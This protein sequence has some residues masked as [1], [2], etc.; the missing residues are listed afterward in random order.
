MNKALR[1]ALTC[2]PVI[3]GG[4]AVRPSATTRI[5]YSLLRALCK[6]LLAATGGVKVEGM[7]NL[8]VQGALILV[9]NHQSLL[10]PLVLM[11]C[12]P[13]RITFL[14][15][16]YL[17]Q[18]PVVGQVI[19]SAGSMPV[20]QKK[21]DL[22]SIR[23][24]LAVLERG[25]TIGLFPEG[26]VSSDGRL[27]HPM[28]GWAYLALKSGAPVLPIG[29]TG[30]RDVL[31]PGTFIL[32]RRRICVKVGRPLMLAKAAVIRHEDLAVLNKKLEREL[33]SLLTD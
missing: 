32:R 18:I 33:L 10:D 20:H 17:F 11:A 2:R 30:S 21:S 26:G 19:R 29:I 25:G 9:S 1:T 12:I 13:R 3:S 22:G 4:S 5:M 23:K 27:R 8:E 14:A 24:S 28:P 16:S 31:A 7:T 15:A 6:L